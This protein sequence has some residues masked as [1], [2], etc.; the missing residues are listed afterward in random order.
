MAFGVV[1]IDVVIL[2]VGAILAMASCE[3]QINVHKQSNTTDYIHDAPDRPGLY[4]YRS[5]TE[6]STEHGMG[7]VPVVCSKRISVRVARI[8]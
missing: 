8:A 6:P 2:Y 4:M 7:C 3:Q 5:E 1:S